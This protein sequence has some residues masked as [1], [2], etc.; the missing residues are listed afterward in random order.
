MEQCRQYLLGRH[1]TQQAMLRRRYFS[2]CH[3]TDRWCC[4]GATTYRTVLDVDR[5][6]SWGEALAMRDAY[7]AEVRTAGGTVDPFVGFHLFTTSKE[8]GKT[9]APPPL[10]ALT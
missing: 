10:A 3:Q 6:L 7:V 5:G 9:G 2:G 4:A 1:W 8:I